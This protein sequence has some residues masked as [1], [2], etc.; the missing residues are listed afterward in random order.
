MIYRD[1]KLD[2]NIHRCNVKRVNFLSRNI[3]FYS[4]MVNSYWLMVYHRR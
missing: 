4:L 3:K 1:F 2:H